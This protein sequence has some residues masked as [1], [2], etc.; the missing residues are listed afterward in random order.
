MI[1][2]YQMCKKATRQPVARENRLAVIRRK[3]QFD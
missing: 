3:N 2:D 1:S